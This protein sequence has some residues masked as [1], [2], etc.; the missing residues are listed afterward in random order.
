CT[1]VCR[2]H[3]SVFSRH[4]TASFERRKPEREPAQYR[5]TFS[6]TPELPPADPLGYLG[7]PELRS[8]VAAGWHGSREWL[9]ATAAS[10]YP[11][12]VPQIV[13]YFDSPRAGEILIFADEGWAFRE[14]GRG[15][16]GAALAADMHVPM[17]FA[18]PDL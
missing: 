1:Q 2:G 6:Q 4:G 10:K 15:E 7:N 18:G 9:D 17:F 13:E 14:H 11:D 8:F 16:H 12:F 3:V 5:L